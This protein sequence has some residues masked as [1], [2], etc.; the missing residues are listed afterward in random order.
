MQA[1]CTACLRIDMSD[2]KV[3]VRTCIG[4]RESKPKKELVRIVRTPEG[5]LAVDHTGKMNGRGAY[6]CPREACLEGAFKGGRLAKALETEI[7]GETLAELKSSLTASE[8]IQ[9]R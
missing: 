2:R 9:R 6:V 8:E 3:P 7:S 1:P 5:R 4:C